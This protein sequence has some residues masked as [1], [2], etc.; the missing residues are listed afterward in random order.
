MS[1]GYNDNV[2]HDGRV[3][4][5]Q[6]EDSGEKYPHIIS[7][8]FADGG[9]IL[10][11][12]K[13]SYAEHVGKDGLV[14]IVRTM[15]Q[16]QHQAMCTAL[17]TGRFDYLWDPDAPLPKSLSNPGL[18]ACTPLEALMQSDALRDRSLDEILAAYLALSA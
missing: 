5:V 6:T 1:G 11:T 3:F 18:V 14:C 8:L 16:R 7:H 17:R 13:S 2:L 12:K 10:K 4:H 15:M 9:A